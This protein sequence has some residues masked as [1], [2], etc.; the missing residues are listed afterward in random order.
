MA[1]SARWDIEKAS[2]ADYRA[3]REGMGKISESGDDKDG[4]DGGGGAQ[5]TEKPRTSH[6]EKMNYV[7]SLY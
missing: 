4:G 2:P 5:K 3:P 6:R 1:E 7:L